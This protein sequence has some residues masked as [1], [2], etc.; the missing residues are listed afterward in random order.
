MNVQH[1]LL[2]DEAVIAT[3]ENTLPDTHQRDCSLASLEFEDG[4]HSKVCSS[5]SAQITVSRNR[6]FSFAVGLSL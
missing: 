4:P 3:G 1:F 5:F 2:V 6:S